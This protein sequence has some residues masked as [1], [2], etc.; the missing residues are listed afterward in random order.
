ML[1][2]EIGNAKFLNVCLFFIAWKWPGA[3]EM[4]LSLFL[5]LYL[6]FCKFQF[7]CALKCTGACSRM[8][9]WCL[10]MNANAHIIVGNNQNESKINISTSKHKKNSSE[11]EREKESELAGEEMWEK[12]MMSWSAFTII[13]HSELCVQKLL[14]SMRS[15]FTLRTYCFNYCIASMFFHLYLLMCTLYISSEYNFFFNICTVWR[16]LLLPSSL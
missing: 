13:H 15:F 7:I 3:R 14:F 4:A 1:V 16:L 5:F 8:L 12:S 10:V 2:Y 6:T 9:H 11:F